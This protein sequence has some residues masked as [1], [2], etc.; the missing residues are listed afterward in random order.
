MRTLKIQ[1]GTDLF[2]DFLEG[3]Y[4]KDILTTIYGPSGSGKTTLCLLAAIAQ[5]REKK[6][7]I[8]IDT[9]GGFSIER[10]KQLA[11]KDI[12]EVLEHIIL[13]KPVSLS[14]QKNALE[15]LKNMINEKIGLIVV[16]TLTIFYRL[17]LSK[18]EDI[19]TTNNNLI[20]QLSYLTE[21]ARK[22]NI[23]ILITNQ[24]YSDFNNKDDVK[25]VGGNILK[26]NSKCLIKLKK[27]PDNKRNA[28]L[29]TH[30]SIPE[31]KE[32]VFAIINE[33]I[34]LAKES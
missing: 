12:N 16:D 7:T 17:E 3:G 22:K 20:W 1:T 13:L 27:Q 28:I 31:G 21:I 29:M 30:R 2:D 33:G 8:Y 23:P 4:E 25:M 32:I 18:N 11:G 15:K 24:V 14:E 9:E 10:M 6:K 34:I 19:K 5:A 26:Y